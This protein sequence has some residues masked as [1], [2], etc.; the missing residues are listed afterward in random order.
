MIM[1]AIK[2]R[3]GEIAFISL[4]QRFVRLDANFQEVQSFPAQIDYWGGR[5]DVLANGHVIVPEANSNRVVEYDTE[6]QVVWQKEI[7]APIAAV[8]LPNGNTLITRF[9]HDRGSKS[10]RPVTKCGPINARCA[11]RMFRR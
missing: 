6:G 10:T 9:S 1:K 5:L 7:P 2:L 3:N 8:R 11:W 4:N